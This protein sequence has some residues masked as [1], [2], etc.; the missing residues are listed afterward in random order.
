MKKGL[1]L[2]ANISDFNTTLPQTKHLNFFMGTN[3]VRY[4]N[5]GAV[6]RGVP[7]SNMNVTQ[8]FLPMALGFDNGGEAD[9]TVMQSFYGFLRNNIKNYLRDLL[10]VEPTD[11][12]VEDFTKTEQGQQVVEQIEQNFKNQ[13]TPGVS[14]GPYDSGFPIGGA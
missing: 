8:G 5:G 11:Q 1:G 9:K 7:M 2:Q 13:T 4:A 12:Q 14:A 6:R 3:P 10:G